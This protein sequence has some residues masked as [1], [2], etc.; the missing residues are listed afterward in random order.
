MLLETSYLLVRGW[1]AKEHA[2]GDGMASN[3]GYVLF[4]SFKEHRVNI[5]NSN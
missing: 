2:Y 4:A 5:C 1:K 3:Q